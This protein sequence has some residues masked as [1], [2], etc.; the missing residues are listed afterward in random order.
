MDELR[1][2]DFLVL[3]FATAVVG[4]SFAVIC[5]LDFVTWLGHCFFLNSTVKN[6]LQ[7]YQPFGRPERSNCPNFPTSRTANCSVEK[8]FPVTAG[9]Q[10]KGTGF[11]LRGKDVIRL[12]V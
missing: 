6:E 1:G 3:G 5:F 11:R 9:I 2:L 4:W 12:E 7:D 10:G 8:P